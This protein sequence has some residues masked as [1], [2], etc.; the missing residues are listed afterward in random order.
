MERT[1]TSATASI[2]IS[3]PAEAL[4]QFFQKLENMPHVFS[5]LCSVTEIDCRRFR[6]VAK[7]P[8]AIGGIIEWEATIVIEVPNALIAWQSI[9][10]LDPVNR[11]SVQLTQTLGSCGTIVKIDV[12]YEGKEEKLGSIVAQLLGQ[13]ADQQVRNDLR[14]FKKVFETGAVPPFSVPQC[15]IAGSPNPESKSI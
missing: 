8:S 13:N 4:F 7:A 10:G 14:N 5:H 6:W 3:R 11:G 2:M 15:A 12:T 1:V 9:P